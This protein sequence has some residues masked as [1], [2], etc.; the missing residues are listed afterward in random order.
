MPMVHRAYGEGVNARDEHGVVHD[1][2]R[3]PRYDPV[4]GQHV[5]S[6]GFTWCMWLFTWRD[7]PRWHPPTDTLEGR[8]E[9]TEDAPNCL[10]CVGYVGDL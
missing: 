2:E 5:V 3:Q 9:K 1:V 8:F 4:D 6:A 10:E 7:G